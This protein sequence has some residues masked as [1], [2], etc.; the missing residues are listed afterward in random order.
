MV[1]GKALLAQ[2]AEAFGGKYV[3]PFLGVE[4]GSIALKGLHDAGK[5]SYPGHAV[6]AQVPDQAKRAAR[7]EYTM[8]FMKRFRRGKP[9]KR[10]RA[11]D[12]VDRRILQRYGLGGGAFGLDLW[13][14]P[15]QL[16]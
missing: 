7:P 16:V 15:D 10:L 13:I 1:V 11:H 12:R 8:D 4:A 6:V 9:M 14:L 3:S 2:R 5:R